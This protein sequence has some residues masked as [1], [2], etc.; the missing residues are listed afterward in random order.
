MMI[1][2]FSCKEPLSQTKAHLCLTIIYLFP[3][4]F[5][6]AVFNRRRHANPFDKCCRLTSFVTKM[7]HFVIARDDLSLCFHFSHRDAF[8]SLTLNNRTTTK[9]M[10]TLWFWCFA[11]KRECVWIRNVCQ[12]L[13]TIKAFRNGTLCYI[14]YV[15]IPLL[16]NNNQVLSVTSPNPRLMTVMPMMTYI[17]WRRNYAVK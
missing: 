10:F 14:F 9:Q 15:A 16:I 2:Y 5:P 6:C 8:S 7:A 3:L 4:R 13:L 11:F 1:S 17:I 12:T